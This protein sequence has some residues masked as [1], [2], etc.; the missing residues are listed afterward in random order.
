MEGRRKSLVTERYSMRKTNKQKSH[1]F[2][3][4][5]FKSEKAV[6]HNFKTEFPK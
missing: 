3:L 4:P 1:R 6:I 2:P 5:L